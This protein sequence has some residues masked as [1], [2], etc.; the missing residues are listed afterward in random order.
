MLYVL[1]RI[2][3]QKEDEEEIDVNYLACRLF[4]RK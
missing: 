3:I 1:L 4:I 2:L